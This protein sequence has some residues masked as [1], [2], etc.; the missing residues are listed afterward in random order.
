[1]SSTGGGIH[2][3]IGG[4]NGLVVAVVAVALGFAVVP[5]VTGDSGVSC[6]QT[7]TTRAQV[8]TAL[9]TAANG[10]QTIC[11]T[12]DITGATITSS[13]DMTGTTPVRL[14]AQPNNMTID[15]VTLALSGANDITI[16]GFDFNGT[17]LSSWETG[18]GQITVKKNYFHDIAG[19]AAIRA[20]VTGG[21]P[22]ADITIVGNRF[23]R[24][25]CTATLT[26]V[27][28]ACV[29][30]A[31][32]Y[33][34][35]TASSGD[36]ISN[37]DFS[38]N[39]VEVGGGSS[40]IVK[41]ADGAE[42]SGLNGYLIDHNVF[43]NIRYCGEVPGAVCTDDGHDPHVDTLGLFAG[44]S[45]GTVS[46]NRFVDG[47]D[48][49][50][51]PVSTNLDMVNNLIVNLPGANGCVDMNYNGVN[52]SNM[53]WQQNTVWGCGGAGLIMPGGSGS[54]NVADRNLVESYGGCTAAA[55]TD[56]NHSNLLGQSSKTCWPGAT[57]TTSFS[58]TWGSTGD[59]N[60]DNA[61]FY[62]ATNLPGGAG[63]V[64]YTYT[65]AGHTACSC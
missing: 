59:A 19:A 30:D 53:T 11:V 63:S 39:T 24:V 36:S 46:N 25:S 44:S 31:A 6:D 14:V 28:A 58:P 21:S 5:A 38:Y 62:I 18:T 10:G 49:G 48:V 32:G 61:N 64:G 4:R 60:W 51:P 1:M 22:V 56:S 17:N 50:I 34:L 37:L 41:S 55:W 47:P 65:P 54:G 16:E 57:N 42:L 33:A 23:Y 26:A 15:M 45:N 3:F 8:A 9:T 13:T 27:T 52:P 20:S 7:V 40:E 12:A 35:Y 43:K 2:A 29:G